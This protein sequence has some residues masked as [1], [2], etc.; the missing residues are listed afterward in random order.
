MHS[1]PKRAEQGVSLSK[2]RDAQVDH[3]EGVQAR[4]TETG[5]G[6]VGIMKIL[7]CHNLYQLAGG[8]D[9]VVNDERELLESQGHEVVQYTLHN[10]AVE[11]LS[12]VRLAAG[13]IWSRKSARELRE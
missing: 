5:A 4:A 11:D 9:S 13:T 1:T 12:R 10:A 3:P 2:T 7:Q 8:E 6:Q